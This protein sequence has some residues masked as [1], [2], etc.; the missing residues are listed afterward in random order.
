MAHQHDKKEKIYKATTVLFLFLVTGRNSDLWLPSSTSNS[1]SSHLSPTHRRSQ[2]C[3]LEGLHSW[4]SESSIVWLPCVSCGFY[5]PL[6]LGLEVLRR[7]HRPWNCV[8]DE[9]FLQFIQGL[10]TLFFIFILVEVLWSPTGV[11]TREP[12]FSSFIP[13]INAALVSHK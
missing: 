10:K 12:K 5:P 4:R 2:S 11:Y 7:V 13:W 8:H 1:V 6:Q 3:T 9:S